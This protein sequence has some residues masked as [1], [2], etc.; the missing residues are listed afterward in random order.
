ML[1]ELLLFI[2]I[3]THISIYRFLYTLLGI[4]TIKFIF[5]ITFTIS[6]RT[7]IISISNRI[8]TFS[9]SWVIN[10]HILERIPMFSTYTLSTLQAIIIYIFTTC[11]CLLINPRIFQIISKK[12]RNTISRTRNTA[13]FIIEGFNKNLLSFKSLSNRTFKMT[14]IYR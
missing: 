2:D 8:T 7:L 5:S 9:S 10:T 4:R 13:R 3:D 6:F 14:T 12:T 11:M 1:T